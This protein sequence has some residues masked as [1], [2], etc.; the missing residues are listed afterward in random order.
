MSN[1]ITILYGSETGNAEEYA[2]YLKLRLKSYN[3][4]PT[5][6]S[7]D[8]FPLKNL[9]TDTDY[10]IIICSTTGQGELP[11]NS[12]SFMKFICKKKLPR[13]FFQHLR[14]TTL[15]LGDSSYTKYNYAIKKIHARMMQLG[16]QELSPR[17]E[18]DEMSPEGVDG[19]YL[20]WE[21]QLL[22]A[23]S[24]FLPMSTEPDNNT[25]PMPEYKMSL[26][27]AADSLAQNS[28]LTK[29][30]NNL[31]VGTVVSNERITTADHFQDVRRLKISSQNLKYNPGDTISLYPCNF[32]QDVETLLELQPQ[33]LEVADKPLRIRNLVDEE[34]FITLRNLIK[35][36]LDIMSIPRRSFFAVLWHFCDSST[37]DGKREQEKLREFGSFSDPEEL[38]NYANRPR[39]SILETLTEFKNNL[40]IPVSYILDL[41]PLIKPRMFSIASRSSETEIEVVVAIVEYRTIIRRIR[42]GLCTRWLKSLK[43]GD[44]VHL[45]IDRSSFKITQSPIIMVAPGTGIA[46]MKSLVDEI[47]HQNSLQEMYLFFGCRHAEKDHLIKSFWEKSSNLHIYNCF[48]RDED[49]EFKYVQDAIIAEY[50]LLGDLLLNQDAKVFVCGSSGKMPREVKLTFVEVVKR[51]KNISKEDAKRY[52]NEMEDCVRYKEDAW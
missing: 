29:I 23:L 41:I 20:E 33:W 13:D 8:A 10:L 43:V 28:L 4:K 6:S 35:Y 50:K 32:D 25:V 22:A 51:F 5:L 1:R 12:K 15:G 40:T 21:T 39:R 11:R 47:L 31:Q 7:L 44:E 52:I 26:G 48:S 24:K 2:K 19:F 14:L 9:V 27:L 36:H 45:S 37:E 38:Y 34:Q 16:C 49:S 42:R 30:Y 46:P 3:L 17:C 18:A